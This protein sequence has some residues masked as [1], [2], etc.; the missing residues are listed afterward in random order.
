MDRAYS[1]QKPKI[2]HAQTFSEV[3]LSPHSGRPIFYHRIHSMVNSTMAWALFFNIASSQFQTSTH[4]HRLFTD[5]AL[6]S[7]A[8]L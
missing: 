8:R 2:Q 5:Y 6:C 1:T 7:H 4:I 3:V